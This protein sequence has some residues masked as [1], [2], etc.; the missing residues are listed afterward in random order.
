[1]NAVEHVRDRL[2]PGSRCVLIGIGG[3]GHLAL[4]ILQVMTPAR[5]IAVD[6]LP[7]RLADAE[8]LGAWR[9]VAAGPEAA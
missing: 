2:G 4:Q 6:T 9:C 3:L 1:M 7:E 8:R 5:V